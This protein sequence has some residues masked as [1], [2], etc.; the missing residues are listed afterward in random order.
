MVA[1]RTFL[2]SDERIENVATF[3]AEH[4]RESVLPLHYKAFLVAMNRDASAK[5]KRA[6]DKLL[7]QEWT[8]AVYTENVADKVDRPLV[9]E[10]QLDGEQEKNACENFKKAAENPE[11]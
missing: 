5:Y 7:P 2:T 6:L 3:V 9:A 1:L 4:F 11:G 8:A 10:L